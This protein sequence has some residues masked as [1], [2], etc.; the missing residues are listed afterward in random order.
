MFTERPKNEYIDILDRI[1]ALNSNAWAPQFPNKETLQ[2]LLDALKKHQ[3]NKILALED[4]TSLADLRNTLIANKISPLLINSLERLMGNV[5]QDPDEYT[6]FLKGLSLSA[7]IYDP[8]K[9]LDNAMKGYRDHPELVI[10][11]VLELVQVRR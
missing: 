1:R 10:A 3:I 11:R 7:C 5:I 9:G 6:R 2:L 4:T 8:R